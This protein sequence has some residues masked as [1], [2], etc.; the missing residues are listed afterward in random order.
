M[1]A[2]EAEGERRRPKARVGEKEKREA[3]VAAET[4]REHN[5]IITISSSRRGGERGTEFRRTAQGGRTDSEARAGQ[6]QGRRARRVRGRPILIVP[7]T[8]AKLFRC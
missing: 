5:G 2:R 4:A 3:A 6:G 1:T 8:M 7:A